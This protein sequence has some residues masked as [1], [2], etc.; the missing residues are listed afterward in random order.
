MGGRQA[1]R[2]PF[3]RSGVKFRI[4]VG[5]LFL[6]GVL[7]TVPAQAVSS[8]LSAQRLLQVWRVLESLPSGRGLVTKAQQTWKLKSEGDFL[9]HLKLGSSSRTDA[10]LTRHFSSETGQEER[11][12]E[13]TIFLR[14]TQ[15]DLELLLDLSHEL[16]HATSRPLFD[17]YDPDLS[18]VHYIQ[19]SIDG[20]GG[21]VEAVL[22][23]CAVAEEW[24]MRAGQVVH[25]CRNY[26]DA[27]S[28]SISGQAGEIRKRISAD[29]YRVG[30]WLNELQKE[31][32]AAISLL[33]ELNAEK[34]RLYSSTEHTPYPVAL[35]QEYAEMTQIACKNSLE[36]KRILVTHPT[37]RELGQISRVEKFLATRCR[38]GMSVAAK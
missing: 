5:L 23:E 20:E 38:D 9:K 11:E 34:P 19:S 14:E 12:R 28:H 25:R 31:L 6:G 8:D 32:G 18:A 10:V 24:G 17:P 37:A 21:E 30:S 36:R 4:A 16:V 29:F 15:S 33:P 3:G 7:N 1:A 2:R 22:A 27:K 13:V 35:Y 26:V